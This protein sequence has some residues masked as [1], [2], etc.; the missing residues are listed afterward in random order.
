MPRAI[1]AAV[2]HLR[3][4][5]DVERLLLEEEQGQEPDEHQR[6]AEQREQEELDRRVLAVRAT[7]DADHEEHREQH[8]LEEDEEQDEVLSDERAVHADLEQQDQREERLRVV[9]LREVVP[10]VDDAQHR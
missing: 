4:D 7:P 1:Q 9:R 3:E 5:R 10:R 8:D 6:R 2:A